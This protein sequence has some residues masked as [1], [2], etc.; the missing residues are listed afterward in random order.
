VLI[1]SQLYNATTSDPIVV[2]A[3]VALVLLS[4][5]LFACWLPARRAMRVDPLVALRAE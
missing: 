5:A 3:V 4:V 1:Y 2:S